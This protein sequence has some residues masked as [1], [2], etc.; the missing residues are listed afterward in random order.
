[1]LLKNF[2]GHQDTCRVSVIDITKS[3]FLVTLLYNVHYLSHFSP[4]TAGAQLHNAWLGGVVNSELRISE[5]TTEQ[6]QIIDNYFPK[7]P[8]G[9]VRPPI[10]E[11]DSRAGR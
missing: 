7:W 6:V 11:A 4:W 10:M 9:T 1:M 3:A 5:A 8:G 2:G